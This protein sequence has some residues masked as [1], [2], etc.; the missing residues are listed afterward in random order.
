M[1]TLEV[2]RIAHWVQ[3]LQDMKQEHAEEQA[4]SEILEDVWRLL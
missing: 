2:E 1:E 4:V 3:G